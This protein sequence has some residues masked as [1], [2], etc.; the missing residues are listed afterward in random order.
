MV[1]ITSGF[2]MK[3]RRACVV[4]VAISFSVAPAT[5]G[6]EFARVLRNGDQA[7]LSVYGPR[8]VDLA[9]K[10]LVDEFGVAVNVEDPVS[11]Y[12]ED[13]QEI[14]VTRS[15]EPLLIP[16]AWPLE[17]RLALRSSGSLRNVGQA[18]RELA[19]AASLAS[20]FQYRIDTD[21]RVHTL[22]PSR[23]RDKHGRSVELP[24]ILD[25]RVTIPPGT[26]RIF[27]HANLLMQAL[28]QQ[29][30]VRISCCQTAVAG[31]PWGST[32]VSFEARNEVARSALLR[33]LRREPGRNR[34]ARNESGGFVLV[35]SDPGREHWHWL[36]RCQPGQAWCFINVAAV[37]EKP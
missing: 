8:P 31:I 36:M 12:R 20:P 29:T 10:K 18:V 4:A 11:M 34:L 23:T 35:K 25:R 22:I 3:C 9:A 33:L 15:G 1:T 6:Q 19:E 14:G 27:E 24:P 13:V 16:K 30:G 7:T 2:A 28:Q 37:P 21:G 5:Q 32:V 26:R 17:T